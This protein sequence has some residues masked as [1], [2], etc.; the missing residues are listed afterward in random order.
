MGQIY[1]KKILLTTRGD[2]SAFS[3]KINASHTTMPPAMDEYLRQTNVYMME[4]RTKIHRM[5]PTFVKLQSVFL[6]NMKPQPPSSTKNDNENS[7]K[8][9]VDND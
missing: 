4:L 6:Y 1:I 5:N 9:N 8:D 3:I 2:D 7:N